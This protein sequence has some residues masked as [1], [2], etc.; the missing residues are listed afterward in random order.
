[1]EI[2]LFMKDAL[3]GGGGSGRCATRRHNKPEPLCCGFEEALQ[4]ALKSIRPLSAEKIPLVES[5]GRMAATDLFSRVDSPA[6]DS[7]RKDGYAVASVDIAGATIS[8]PVSLKISGTLAAGEKSDI[9]LDSGATVR[10]LTGARTPTGADAVVAEEYVV[11]KGDTVFFDAPIQPGKNV[12]FRGSDVSLDRRL[13]ASGQP[14]TPVVAGLLAAGGHSSVPV[15]KTPTVGIVGTGDE[16][17]VP[18]TP[19]KE[20]QL[21]ASNI[22][23]L[24]GWCRKL[25]ITARMT[26]V[27]DDYDTLYGTLK[28]YLDKTDALITSGGAWTGDRDFVARALGALGWKKIFH[29]IRMGPGKA[30]GFGMLGQKPVFILAG[31]PPSNLMG[32]VQIALPGLQALCGHAH[33]GLPTITARLTQDI[34]DGKTDWTDMYY[35]TL[36]AGDGLPLFHPMKKRSRLSA[37]GQATAVACIPEGKE[38]LPAGSVVVVQRIP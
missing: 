5:V 31:G 10:V 34:K 9:V 8:S 25:G 17:V 32:F 24:A 15:R 19:L 36:E 18:G 3:P 37:I 23:T 4:L 26:T 11:R 7:S 22:V 13:V 6:M 29:R 27:Q 28:A 14:I 38:A 21:Y 33:P 2:S 35:G 12:L 30:V 20:G 1:M 16:I